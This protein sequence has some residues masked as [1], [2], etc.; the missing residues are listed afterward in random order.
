MV[1]KKT[2]A[3]IFM[4]PNTDI[5]FVVE[6]GTRTSKPNYN[7][8]RGIPDKMAPR[9]PEALFHFGTD[10]LNAGSKDFST[11]TANITTLYRYPK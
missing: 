3:G 11:Y 10:L 8:F 2:G 5:P 6:S 4:S 1:L 7:S 9:K